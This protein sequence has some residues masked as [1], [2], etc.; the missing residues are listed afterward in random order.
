MG[1][2]VAAFLLP[3]ALEE[4]VVDAELACTTVETLEPSSGGAT[5]GS[6]IVSL[7]CLRSLASPLNAVVASSCL[8]FVGSD[9]NS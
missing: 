8:L 9:L 2:V 5:E 4:T 1:S 3:A 7:G 6:G